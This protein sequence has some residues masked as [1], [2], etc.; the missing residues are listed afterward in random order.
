MNPRNRIWLLIVVVAGLGVVALGYLLGIAPKL[1]EVKTADAARAEAAAVNE[2]YEV[3]LAKLKKDYEGIDDIQ[4]QLDELGVQLPAEAGYDIYLTVVL[5]TA[6]ASG[7]AATDFTWGIPELVTADSAG[8]I[9]QATDA[10]EEDA[11]PT[12][13]VVTGV[14]PDGGLVGLPWG[15]TVKGKYDALR[16]FMYELQRTNRLF[17]V[18]GFTIAVATGESAAPDEY[19]MTLNGL[20]YVLMNSK[21]TN[22]E[23][24]GAET[25]V[26]EPTPA[27][28]PTDTPTPDPTAS[29]T[30]K[31]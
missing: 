31:P 13:P 21:V 8:L 4:D 27:P 5:N 28:T 12:E 19:V 23:A 15:V 11:A 24:D 10:G 18:T 29:A 1:E 6:A 17:L 25:P 16:A 9:A 30:P 7:A 14:A 22:K 20:T 2:S 3:E 26:E